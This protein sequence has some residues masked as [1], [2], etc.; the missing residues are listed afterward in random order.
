MAQVAGRP[1]T[2]GRARG[3]RPGAPGGSRGRGRGVPR[4]IWVA[5]ACAIVVPV[6]A[7]VALF[8]LA[9]RSATAAGLSLGLLDTTVGQI[10][11]ARPLPA[12][13][14][15]FDRSNRLLAYV[16]PPGESRLPIPLER[17]SPFV[18]QATIA[19]EDRNFWHG[20]AVD[21]VRIVAAA[22][23]DLRGEGSL[24]GAS[25]ITQQLAKVK[26]LNDAPTLGRKIREL[27]V[28]RHLESSMSKQQILQE[29]LN[30]IPYGHGA[31]GI[32]AAAQ[33]YFGVDASKLTLPQAA[34]LAG[35]RDAPS[36]LDP[37]LHPDAAKQRQ[38]VVLQAM[39]QTGDISPEQATAAM[40]EELT[41]AKGNQTNLNLA[42]A[43]VGRVKAE[44]ANT[45]KVDIATAGLQIVTTLDP[46]LQDLAEKTVAKQVQ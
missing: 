34:L 7:L 12:D 30:S 31:T 45:L 20:G 13:S 46:A 44:L 40:A 15:V 26:Y 42:P 21:P 39:V 19:V 23:H 32:Q 29:Y 28:A 41:F 37:L 18:Q 17:M 10:P 25:T 4:G 27:F 38:R 14:I 24:Q 43:F 1:P 33:T 22:W 5:I 16:H 6:I 11:E 8:G 9:A 3:V 36:L 35:L 2:M